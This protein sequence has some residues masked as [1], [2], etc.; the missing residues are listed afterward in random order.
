MEW[1]FHI[2]LTLIY[3]IDSTGGLGARVMGQD[4][5]VRAMG[6]NKKEKPEPVEIPLVTVIFYIARVLPHTMKLRCYCSLTALSAASNPTLE[7][8]PSQK[9]FF[10]DAPQ[11]QRA[12]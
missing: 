10:T 11:R 1:F 4:R 2:Y 6:T 3:P 5:G 8:V 9:G 7:W 12:T